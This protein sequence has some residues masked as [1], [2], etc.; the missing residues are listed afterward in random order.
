MAAATVAFL[1]CSALVTVLTVLTIVPHFHGKSL[2]MQMSTFLGSGQISQP[3]FN[4]RVLGRW[5]LL[6]EIH[7]WCNLD[8]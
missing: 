5:R 7:E 4:A 6:G 1:V 8:E 3:D 2:P